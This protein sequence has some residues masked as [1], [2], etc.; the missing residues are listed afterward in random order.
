MKLLIGIV[1]LL[2]IILLLGCTSGGT[3]KV[4]SGITNEEV[5]AI[6]TDVSDAGTPLNDVSELDEVDTSGIEDAFN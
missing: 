1:A 6:S 4:A 5:N 2:S 3:G